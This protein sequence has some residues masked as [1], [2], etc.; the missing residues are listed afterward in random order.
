VNVVGEVFDADPATVSFFQGGKT[1][2]GVDT[3]VDTLF[4]YPVYFKIVDAFSGGKSIEEIPK[5]LGH[6]YLYPNPQLLWTFTANHDVPRLANSPGVTMDSVKLAYTCLFTIRGVPLLYYGDEI[7]MKGANDPDNR[8]DF[9]G[10]WPGDSVN[11]FTSSG[12]SAEQSAIFEHVRKLAH[13]RASVPALAH[14]STMNL[15]LLDQQWAY[16]RGVGSETAIVVM[17]NDSKPASLN[18]PLE[19]VRLPVGAH[20]RGLLGIIPEASA[21]DRRL[22]VS[23]PARSAEI[24]VVQQ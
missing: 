2:D 6:D 7:A 21:A 23:V 3:L 24:F 16:A 5:A 8:R 10:G 19:E 20:L 1:H 18:V 14:G 11:A 22:S 17:N 9:P 13:L 12:R 15:V 4:D